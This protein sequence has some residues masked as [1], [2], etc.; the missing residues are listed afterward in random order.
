MQY[1]RLVIEAGDSTFT[2]D[3]HPRLTVIGGVGQMER[4][5]LISE[6]VGS[7]GAGRPGVHLELIADSGKRFAIFRPHGARHRVVDVDAAVDVTPDFRN[8][9]GSIDLLTRAGMDPRSAR[10][11]MR[12]T[13]ID[14]VTT[15]ER[16]R[17]IQALAQVNQN[18]LWV[19]AEALRQAQR[20][21][22][23]EADAVGT[24]AEDA[25]VIEKIEERHATF[26]RSQQMIERWRKLTFYISGFAA[27]GV[28]PAVTQVG[29]WAAVPL[30]LLAAGATMASIAMWRRNERAHREEEEALS[31]AGA[32]SY[33]GF[34][35]QRVNGLLSSDQARKRLMQA[36]EEH[37]EAQK[38]WQ[39]IAGEIDLQ[40]A[41][42][43]RDEISA[44]VKLRQDVVS[45]GMVAPTTESP[46]NERATSLAH[47]VVSR[48][49]ELRKLGPG[50]ESFPALLD[51]PFVGVEAAIKP[52]LLELLVRS[53]QHQQ[54]V[55]LTSDDAIVQWARLE[56]MTG[57]LS[58]VEPTGGQRTEQFGQITLPG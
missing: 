5:G 7:L 40:W 23:E 38:R 47:A 33:L 15:K 50:N 37:R 6:L 51:E 25:E 8:P 42:G 4:D 21:L 2:L 43:H 1:E 44:A 39:V 13:S 55:L 34:H 31:E 27:I 45:L 17:I 48:L 16:D 14:L 10:Q 41:I 58:I 49:S 35:L 22:D 18:E 11:A 56:A 29:L 46:D 36:S 26:E 54:V 28:I 53:S 3:L 19:A 20:R 12:F 24:N 9:D 52:S 32:Q 30:I 57:A